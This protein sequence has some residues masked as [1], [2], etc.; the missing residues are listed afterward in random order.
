MRKKVLGLVMAAM[1][2]STI[3]AFAQ[4]EVQNT[5]AACEQTAANCNKD[6]GDCKKGKKGAKGDFKKGKKERVSPFAGI[7]LTET[8][9]AQI[10][11]LKAERKADKEKAKKADKEARA[12]AKKQFDTKL[13]QILTP[14]Q[15]AQYQSNCEAKKAAKKDKMQKKVKKMH[16]AGKDIKG[17]RTK[18]AT[19]L[20]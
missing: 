1:A 11:A 13:A 4:T 9:Q 15:Y 18:S 20:N 8:Q 14:E 19:V 7:Q 16:K 12:E 17:E 10:D 5:K 3:G 2:I 6:K